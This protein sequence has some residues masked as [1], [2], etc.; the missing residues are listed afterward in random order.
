MALTKLSDSE[1]LSNLT[2]SVDKQ[3]LLRAF[4]IMLDTWG[5][6]S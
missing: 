5:Y 2:G 3:S 1:S 6:L 4:I